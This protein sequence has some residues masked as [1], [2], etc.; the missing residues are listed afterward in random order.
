[1][2]R[3]ELQLNSVP[4]PSS[5][6]ET[7][8]PRDNLGAFAHAGQTK[9]TFAAPRN[10]DRGIDALTVINYSQPEFFSLVSEMQPYMLCTSVAERI[11]KSFATDTD[12]LMN[13]GWMQAGRNS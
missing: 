9:V 5:L 6:Q 1:M 12:N 4:T 13:N 10:Q 8:S 2:S 3:R 7:K 11:A